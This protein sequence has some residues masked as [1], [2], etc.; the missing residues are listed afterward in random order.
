MIQFGTC[1]VTGCWV[2]NSSSVSLGTRTCGAFVS[3]LRCG[4]GA[5]PD[6]CADGRAF[7]ASR[8]RADQR[9]QNGAAAD[10]FGALFTPAGAGYV[11]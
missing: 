9:A 2:L 7:A 10:P 11:I 3:Y 1:T 4:T 5:T 6:C 8:D